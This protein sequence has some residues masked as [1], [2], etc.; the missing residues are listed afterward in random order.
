MGLVPELAAADELHVSRRAWVGDYLDPNTFLDMYVT[1]GENNSTGFCNAEYDQLIAD[2]AKEPDEAKR[3][4]M[5]ERA[6]RILMDEMPI[7]PIYFYVSQEHGEAARPRLLQ[8]PAG[9]APAAHDL[10][11]PRA[12]T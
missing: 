12:S 4:Q 6:E 8:Q 10:D 1:D 2:A 3:M 9:H 5:L 7:I 11:R